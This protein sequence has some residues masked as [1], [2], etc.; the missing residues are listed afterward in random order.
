M[1]ISVE[2]LAHDTSF[3]SHL[4]IA[5]AVWLWGGRGSVVAVGR[6]G[7]WRRLRRIPTVASLSASMMRQ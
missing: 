3:S 6:L 2:A 5:A 4:A 7:R 1:K